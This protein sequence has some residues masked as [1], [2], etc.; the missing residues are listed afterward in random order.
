MT[1]TLYVPYCR[2]LASPY[3]SGADWLAVAGAAVT[4]SSL[5]GVARNTME[6]FCDLL[7][8][9]SSPLSLLFWPP[10]GVTNERSC[11]SNDKS[12]AP[13]SA[14]SKT[15]AVHVTKAY[16]IVFVLSTDI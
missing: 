10:R 14:H 7:T 13:L 4:S 2:S 11:C 6:L 8:S 3:D 1:C 16:K 15:Q 12:E 5:T 9:S